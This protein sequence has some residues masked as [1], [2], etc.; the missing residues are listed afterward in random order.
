MVV[1]DRNVSLAGLSARVAKTLFLQTKPFCLKYQLPNE[2]LDSLIS[3]AGDEDLENM[4]EEY[5]RICVAAGTGGKGSRLRLFVF[6]AKSESIASIG[7]LLDSSVKSDEW[8]LNALNGSG[9]LNG[10]FPDSASVNCLLGLETDMVGNSGNELGVSTGLDSEFV[11]GGKTVKISNQDVHSVPD[12]PIME[13]TSSF[14]SANSTPLL[15]NLP[16]IKVRK[17]DGGM[18]K[19][20]DQRLGPEVQFVQ[21]SI[22]TAAVENF[23]AMSSPSPPIPT[24]I[25]ASMP[26]QTTVAFPAPAVGDFQ[27][28]VVSDDERS[29]HSGI[30]GYGRKSP[31]PQSVVQQQMQQKPGGIVDSSKPDSFP[32]YFSYFANS[33]PF[34]VLSYH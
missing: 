19:A 23:A 5:D 17:D 14:G 25:I 28:R 21:T 26:V 30:L 15:A 27:N 33:L 31:Q 2:D 7:S 34:A 1:V 12:S 11:N 18:M 13:T 16:P 20:Q 9:V 24:T 4:I 8:F 6:P 10:G 29:D 3:L 22:S 32:R